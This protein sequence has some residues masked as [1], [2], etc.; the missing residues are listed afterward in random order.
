MATHLPLIL[1]DPSIKISKTDLDTG[2]TELA[3]DS[4]HVEI[5]PDTA[6]TTVD[7]FC[8]STDYPGITK[9]ALVVTLI[10]SFDTD[11][12]EEVLSAAVATGQ[13]VPFE[14]IPYKGQAVSATNP[15]W[16]GKVQP[17]PYP[18]I[19]GDAGDVSTIDL[20][21]AIV[22]GP[23]KSIT[24]TAAAE[25]GY[26]SMTVAELQ[27]E[28]EAR[29]LPTSGTKAELIERLSAPEAELVPA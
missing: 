8:G 10:Q 25:G 14:V 21:W 24:V 3:C 13:P 19:N 26:D 28:A 11:A 4:S 12:T 27:T 16:S 1:I 18:P 2:L 22:E 29:G 6:V 7:T 20:E 17:A 5:S 23:T 15:R 9:W